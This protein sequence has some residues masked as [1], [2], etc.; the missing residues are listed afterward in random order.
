MR[1]KFFGI[2]AAIMMMFF[3]FIAKT[4]ETIPKVAPKAG[5]GLE[6]VAK[7]AKGADGI[8]AAYRFRYS[9]KV[10]EDELVEGVAKVWDAA[11]KANTFNK[12]YTDLTK[13]QTISY[14]SAGLEKAV[15]SK[16]FIRNMKNWYDREL[17]EARKQQNDAYEKELKSE[18]FL[19]YFN[20]QKRNRIIV[21]ELN[22][23]FDNFNEE[24]R[25]REE[26]N[27]DDHVNGFHLNIY[28]DS[29]IPYMKELKILREALSTRLRL[30]EDEVQKIACEL[31]ERQGDTIVND[32]LVREATCLYVDRWQAAKDK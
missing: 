9:L 24:I 4:G 3:M 30:R 10:S 13:T 2:V 26:I 1:K 31:M 32:A 6:N 12:L 19:D 22:R 16:L 28:R 21:R 25:S 29:V 20:L 23:C 5:K 8:I 14:G 18:S 17:S 27:I 15:R 7:A 11:N